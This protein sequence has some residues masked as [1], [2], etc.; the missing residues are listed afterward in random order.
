MYLYHAC[1]SSSQKSQL[2]VNSHSPKTALSN[3]HNMSE[4][5]QNL[6]PIEQE[7]TRQHPLQRFKSPDPGLS[8]V[9]HVCCV[10]VRY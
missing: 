3:S 1:I 9:V 6:K 8:A 2:T 10:P 4:S 7:T 5:R